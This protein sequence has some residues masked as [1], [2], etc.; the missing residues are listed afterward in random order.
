M[1][2]LAQVTRTLIQDYKSHPVYEYPKYYFDVAVIILENELE[3]SARI[4][5]ICLPNPSSQPAS[6]S[7][8]VQGW[9]END[10]GNSV[11]RAS[12]VRED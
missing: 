11:K 2:G 12:E 3:F 7:L 4:S 1:Y 9:G 8:T 5:A 10:K 6:N